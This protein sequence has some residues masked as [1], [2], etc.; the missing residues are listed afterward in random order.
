MAKTQKLGPLPTDREIAPGGMKQ[1]DLRTELI[2]VFGFEPEAVEKMKWIELINEVGHQRHTRDSIAGLVGKAPE[3][4]PL[5]IGMPDTKDYIFDGHLGAGP[6][7]AERWMTCT[8]SLAASRAFLET[9]TPNQQAEFAKSNIA[10][11]QGTTAHAAAEVEARFIL[12][13]V[14]EDEVDAVLTELTIMP[15]TEGE[16]YDDEMAEYI[17]EYLDLVKQYHDSGREVLIEHKV[18]AVV[19]L[20]TVDEDGDP[21]VYEIAGSGDCIA[22]PSDEEHELDV[23]DLKYGENIDV[24]VDENPQIRI[25][26]LG[27]LSEMADPKT[28][29]LPD[30]D[31]INYVIAQPR[32]GGMKAW[33]ESVEDLLTWRDE[34]LSP[35]LTE[36][37]GGAKTG[38]KFE[39][40]ELACKWCPARGSCAALAESR[41]EAA[42]EMFDEIVEAEFEG[43]ELDTGLLTDER[44][45]ELYGQILGLTKLAAA[46]KVEVNHRLHRG[47]QVPG[48]HLVSYTPPRT[49]KE[50]AMEE[51]HSG[52]V[53]TPR[54]RKQMWK[55]Q[56]LI[57]PT[58]AI[59]ILGEKADKIMDLIDVP[60][61]R[62]VAA[63]VTDR[64][65]P[66]AGKPPEEMFDIE[67]EA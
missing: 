38:A 11:R 64:R 37:L 24:D 39:P 30:I 34:V 7:G 1:E 10:A 32:L 3:S 41:M 40:S 65:K 26:A 50:E 18:K 55:E 21:H 27:A 16:S 56:A 2:E 28:G 48:F 58:Q 9:L 60:D 59:K 66:W 20:M 25:Y 47:R 63:P 4:T 51:I 17:T 44:L 36:A 67:E 45:G 54:E 23:V 13:E 57:T 42:S 12:G 33:T 46:M 29:Q 6:S 61:K 52:D 5:F 35:A 49:W 19:P 53:L 22:M 62:P 43:E 15:E 14:D 31:R 8:A